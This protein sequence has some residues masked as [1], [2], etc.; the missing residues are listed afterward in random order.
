MPPIGSGPSVWVYLVQPAGRDLF[1]I[2]QVRGSAERVRLE[3]ADGAIVRTRPRAGL[4]VQAIP[5]SQITSQRRA[6]FVVAYTAEGNRVQ[7]QR[8][9]FRASR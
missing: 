9:L 5:R 1:V 4:F 3:F 7:R 8:F 6:A 2:G